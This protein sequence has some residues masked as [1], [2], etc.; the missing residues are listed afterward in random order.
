MFDDEAT[1]AIG[2]GQA[3]FTGAFQPESPLSTFDGGG[4]KGFWT[5]TVSD[6]A[7]WDNG[8]L[9]SW[10]MDFTATTSNAANPVTCNMT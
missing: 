10:K 6:R 7:W 2:N 3:P 9:N 8:T 1:T 5:L 4:S